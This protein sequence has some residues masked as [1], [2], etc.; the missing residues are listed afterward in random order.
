[1][2][3]FRSA[4]KDIDEVVK[5]RAETTKTAGANITV[6]NGEQCSQEWM[7]VVDSGPPQLHRGRTAALADLAPGMRTVRVTGKIGDKT[8]S[9]ANTFAAVAGNV[10]NVSLRLD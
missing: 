1:M 2:Q 7:L 8:V 4:L 5:A 3:E 6:E 10:A 9:A